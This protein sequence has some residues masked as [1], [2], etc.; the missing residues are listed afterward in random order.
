MASVAVAVSMVVPAG[1]PLALLGDQSV[2]V[3]T[4]ATVSTVMLRVRAV[5]V[6]PAASDWVADSV[7]AP[8]PIL[9]MSAGTRV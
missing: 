2:F 8:W 7:S 9:V 3:K 1:V 5:L 6:L 4:G